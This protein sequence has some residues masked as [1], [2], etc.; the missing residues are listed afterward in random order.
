MSVKRIE[1]EEA[2]ERSLNWLVSKSIELEDP[3]LDPAA[4]EKLMRAYDFVAEAVQ[5]Y[6]RGQLVK[7]YP[8]L[9]EH[10]NTLGWAFDESDPG[11]GERRAEPSKPPETVPAAAEEPQQVKPAAALAGWLDD[12]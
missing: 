3:L 9:C 4:K 12:D 11:H 1:S 7:E 10:Y 5:R 6:R 8:G 2:Y